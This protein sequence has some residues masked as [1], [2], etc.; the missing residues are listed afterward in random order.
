MTPIRLAVLTRL[1]EH[2][3]TITPDTG[4]E[5]DLSRSV[6]RGR[7]LLGADVRER[8]VVS[9]LEA[10]RPDFSTYT[11]EWDSIRHDR[12]TLLVQGLVEDD[13]RN[14]CDRAYYL[15]AAV[16]SHL[17]RVIEVKESTG[18]PKY[19]DVHLLGGLIGGL[20]IGSPI[21]RPPE[22]R[23]SAS[24]FFF[25]PLRLSIAIAAGRPYTDL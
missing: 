9:I 21:V 15:C 20:E 8:P 1:T 25:L 13:P 11:G 6:Y 3:K 24:A 18:A 4:Y 22:D 7:N 16:E 10:P 19:P 17:A 14:P 12:W 23:V 5:F 2:L